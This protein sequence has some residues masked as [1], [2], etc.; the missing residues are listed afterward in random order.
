M[1]KVLPYYDTLEPIRFTTE[2]VGPRRDA[3][4]LGRDVV[5][6][7]AKPVA[8]IEQNDDRYMG[9]DPDWLAESAK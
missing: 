7:P 8:M 6:F 5:T 9:D 4:P 2:N 1:A 3:L